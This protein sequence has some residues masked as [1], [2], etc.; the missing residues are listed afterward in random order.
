MQ[1][2]LEPE[3]ENFAREGTFHIFRLLI[4]S[5]DRHCDIQNVSKEWD[6]GMDKKILTTPMALALSLLAATPAYAGIAVSGPE[7][8]AGLIALTAIAGGY[9]LLRRKFNRT[10]RD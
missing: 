7:A 4:G 3:Q 5:P 9:V 8:G 2:A 10:D 6:L 1:H